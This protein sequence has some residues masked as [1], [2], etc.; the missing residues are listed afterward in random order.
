MRISK[1]SVEENIRQHICYSTN[2]TTTKLLKTIRTKQEK[3]RFNTLH[4]LKKIKCN[5]RFK[6]DDSFS[7]I[8]SLPLGLRN[9]FVFV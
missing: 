2:K 8:S 9:V 6:Y 3:I 4:C 5:F 7:F 1:S